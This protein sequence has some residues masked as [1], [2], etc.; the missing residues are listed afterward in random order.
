MSPHEAGAARRRRGARAYCAAVLAWTVA[1]MTALVLLPP[2]A[3]TIATAHADSSSVTVPGPPVWIPASGT[4]GAKGSVTVSQTQNLVDQIVHVSWSGFTPSTHGTF[5]VFG[6][7]NNGNWNTV[8][9]PVVVYECH[10][11]NPAITDCYGGLHYGQN[12]AAGF[13]LPSQSAGL[14]APDFPGNVAAA[15]T[16]SDGTGAAD[17]E[18]YTANQSPTLGCDASHQCSIVV[19][20]NYGGDALG[21]TTKDGSAACAN[22]G[23]DTGLGGE[24]TGVTFNTVGGTGFQ[25]GEQCAWNNRT[26]VP[27]TF[28]PVPSACPASAAN[29]AAEGMPMLDRA[30]AQW[31]VG[32]CL[33]SSNP[34][35]LRYSSDLT[36]PEARDDFLVGRSG[37]DMA[38]TSL[39]ADPAASTTH[40]Y[41]YVPLGST[42]IAI[43]FFVDD[44]HTHLPVTSMKLNARLVAKLLTQSYDVEN[45]GNAKSDTLSV[46]GNPTCLFQ[47]KE[48][49]A[50][51]QGSGVFWPNCVVAGVNT[52][53]IVAGGNSDLVRELT[54]WIADDPD[55]GAFLSGTPDPYGMHVDTYYKTSAYPYPIENFV[56]QDNSGPPLDPSSGAAWDTSPNSAH[57][58]GPNLKG[59][60][61]NPIQAGLDEVVRHMMQATPTCI[62]WQYLPAQGGSVKCPAQNMGSRSLIAIMDTGRASA[63]SLP[64]AALPNGSG[65]FATPTAPAMAA[66]ALDYTT[67]S[68]TGTQ[69]LPWGS[70]HTGYAGDTTAYPLTLPTYAMAPTSGVSPAKA[71]SIADFLSSATDSRSGQLPGNQPGQLAPG[72]V[73]DTPAQSAQA[74]AAIAKIRA[75]AAP[76]GSTA[77]VTATGPVT[78]QP[79]TSGNT[80][81]TPVTVAKNGTASVSYLT[82]TIGSGDNGGANGGNSSGSSSKGAVAA[83]G[84]SGPAH[85]LTGSTAAAAVGSASADTAGIGRLILPIL[86]IIGLVLVAAGPIALM[87]SSGTAGAR[88]RTIWKRPARRFGR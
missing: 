34:V 79:T 13:Q 48:F 4:T 47:D 77:T 46:Q 65:T 20:P 21:Q 69:S 8:G 67:D 85:S 71:A 1:F 70:S 49:L 86:L 72:Y 43:A 51:N 66:A 42:G 26:V 31:T 50:L 52:L 32:S 55:A 44:V 73:G 36:E 74:G 38:F 5:V 3:H 82:S 80:V 61:W 6:N 17:I 28:A 11:T 12:P 81:V 7:S 33:N 29:V 14:W 23:G 2:G 75:G 9:Y 87:L 60:E 16:H 68:K 88:L 53:P 78:G 35:T 25:D 64:T 83:T 57:K 41:T 19:E 15:V 22:H 63:F 30:L 18:V 62:N 45:F 37:A 76:G 40:P 39:P 84:S 27:L 58:F 10:G 54:T 24:A 56:S 59:F